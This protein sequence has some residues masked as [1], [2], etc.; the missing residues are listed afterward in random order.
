[1]ATRE[2]RK[3]FTKHVDRLVRTVDRLEER[4]VRVVLRELRGARRQIEDQLI[5]ELA[6]KDP[7]DFAPRQATAL[8]N[9]IDQITGDVWSRYES[10]LQ[11]VDKE[12]VEEAAGATA[13]GLEITADDED[14]TRIGSPALSPNV[15]LL[16]T[17]YQAQ[18]ITR[19]QGIEEAQSE[20]VRK[21]SNIVNRGVLTGQSPFSISR[22]MARSG[23]LGPLTRRDGTM[24]GIGA[25]ADTIARTEVNR[26]FNTASVAN[27]EQLAKSGG[28]FVKVWIDAGDTR[29]RPAH[30]VAGNRY[31]IGGDPGP[32]PV[33]E[34]FI[35]VHN[36]VEFRASAPQDTR[37]PPE[38]SI[39]CRCRKVT[40]SAS[41]ARGRAA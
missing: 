25:R 2:Q 29:V 36:G 11:E 23:W 21:L 27:D 31:R 32:I 13:E 8:R 17:R 33:D 10:R 22:D 5:A 26:I 41:F 7:A 1:M 3:R 28:E 35:L 19:S 39:N 4:E 37:L 6:G 16:S 9:S 15:V 12:L 40:M 38:L 24:I 18:L 34:D 14:R 30:E 20:Q